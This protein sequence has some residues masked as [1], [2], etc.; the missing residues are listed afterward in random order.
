MKEISQDV[1]YHMHDNDNDCD[2]DSK[3][4]NRRYTSIGQNNRDISFYDNMLPYLE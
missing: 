3:D 1:K 4:F 2:N